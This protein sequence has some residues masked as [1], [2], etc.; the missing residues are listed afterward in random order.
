VGETPHSCEVG[1]AVELLQ[2]T[3]SIN[4]AECVFDVHFE[5]DEMTRVIHQEVL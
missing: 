2:Q 3:H 5:G 4:V 1:C